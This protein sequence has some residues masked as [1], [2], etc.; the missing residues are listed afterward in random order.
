MKSKSIS[1]ISSN[2]QIVLSILLCF[3]S[4]RMKQTLKLYHA[5]LFLKGV[6]RFCT[7]KKK[8][9]YLQRYSVKAERGNVY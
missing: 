4:S 8:F 5:F 7:C 2:L 6:C 9:K 3:L 1:A